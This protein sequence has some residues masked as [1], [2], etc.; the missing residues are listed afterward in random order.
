MK[1]IS[2]PEIFQNWR[3]HNTKSYNQNN[4]L[5]RPFLSCIPLSKCLLTEKKLL[6][7]ASIQKGD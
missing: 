2:L 4:P 1:E 5:Y 6:A 7:Q 3:G